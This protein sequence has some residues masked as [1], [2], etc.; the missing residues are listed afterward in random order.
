MA[1]SHNISRKQSRGMNTAGQRKSLTASGKLPVAEPASLKKFGLILMMHVC[2]KY[3]LVQIS[4]RL[5]VYFAFLIILSF[6]TDLFPFPQSFFAD[7]KN[8]LNQFFVRFG[9]GW[10]LLIVCL[11]I[12]MTSYT[13]CAGNRNQVRK[14][15]IRPALATV[16]W[17]IA[18]N[19]F[20]FVDGYSGHCSALQDTLTTKKLCVSNGKEWISFDISGHAFLLIHC[21]LTIVEEARCILGWERISE[22]ASKED[23]SR[24]SQMLSEE[25]LTALRNWYDSFTPYIRFNLLVLTVQA[26]VWE[27]MLLVTTIYY[28]NMPE[29]LTGGLFAVGAWI[30]TYQISVNT[31]FVPRVGEGTINYM[32]VSTASH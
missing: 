8:F 11:F 10:T 17:Y 24:Q 7:K 29:K 16:W 21:L 1:S 22:I 30:L 28:H 31:G 15:L 19:F 32:K 2:K 20:N 3:L 5:A 23:D 12:I 6:I 9:W 4:W 14:H 18:T 27:I 25:Q 13:Y 26:V